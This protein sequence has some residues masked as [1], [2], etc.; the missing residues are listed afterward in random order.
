MWSLCLFVLGL[1]SVGLAEEEAMSALSLTEANFKDEVGSGPHFVMFFAPWCGHCK[2][3]APTWEELALKNNDKEDKEV[4]IAK[5]DCTQQTALCSAQDVTGYPTLKFFKSGFEKDDGVKY[6]GNRDLK[7][8]EKFIA[9]KLGHEVPAEEVKEAASGEAVVNDGLH[10]LTEKSFAGVVKEKDTFVK[11]YA[12][13]C[14]HC[15]KLAPTWDELAK[16]F[17]KDDDVKIAKIDCTEHQSICQEN[18]VRGYP[19]LA[20]FRAGRKIETY[21]GARSLSDLKDFVNA[22]KGSAGAGASE[23]GKVPEPGKPSPVLKLENSNFEDE[24]K[25]GIVFV[26]FFAPWCGHCKRLAPTWEQLAEHYAGNEGVKIAHVDC[27][28]DNNVNRAL[29]DGQGVNGFPTLNIYK[30]GEKAEEYSGKR[31]LEALKAFVEKHAA[32]AKETKDEL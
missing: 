3:L 16:V 20:L 7:S 19:T 24:V 21:K 32:P 1:A 5:V 28:A 11:F 22:N 4:T 26:K 23:D 6:R 15:I 29:C 10:I 2:R 18:D 31:D 17:E 8:L 30:D 9:E 25:E 14:G 12:P 13:W 27:T